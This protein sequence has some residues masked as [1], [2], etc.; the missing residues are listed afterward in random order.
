MAIYP[1]HFPEFVHE[2]KIQPKERTASWPGIVK[3]LVPTVILNHALTA[4]AVWW[5]M[6]K[7]NVMT[8][9]AACKA[10]VPECPSIVCLITMFVVQ[11]IIT[12]IVFM[13]IIECCI[14]FLSSI[15]KCTSCTTGT[16]LPRVDL[17]R[18]IFTLWKES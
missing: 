3:K 14:R 1:E 9:G 17:N 8:R 13:S 12:D 4:P 2:F 7:I 15:K 6:H 11:T 10:Q 18:C 5:G 16:L